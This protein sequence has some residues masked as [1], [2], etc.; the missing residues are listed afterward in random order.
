MKSLCEP[1]GMPVIFQIACRL[2]LE[3]EGRMYNEEVKRQYPE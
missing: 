2:L 1:D 3:L